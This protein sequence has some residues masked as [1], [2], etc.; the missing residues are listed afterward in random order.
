MGQLGNASVAL[1]RIPVA[2][3]GV[4]AFVSVS[5]GE[6]HT[7]GIDVAHTLYCWGDN[8][9]GQLGDGTTTAASVP[10]A[11]VGGLS[12]YSV[13]A[14]A[15]HTCAIATNN[16]AYC[17]G[18]NG[19]G[20]LGSGTANAQGGPAAVIGGHDFTSI[21]S[22]AIHSCAVDVA[23]RAWCWGA[24]YWGQ[25]GTGSWYPRS[26]E[27]VAVV[28]GFHF[29]S[30]T[31]GLYAYSDE[32]HNWITSAHTCGMTNDAIALCW[33]DNLAG[34]LGGGIM[35]SSSFRPVRVGPWP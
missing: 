8:S 17:W 26:S 25:L 23:A 6:H 31:A 16:T 24:N 34:Q 28:G 29:A 33:G 9:A 5:A 30:I 20:Q 1:S 15:E 19:S 11:V 21:A 2:V 32:S 13:S 14:G 27:P 35:E 18:S 10:T 22:G 7:C 3:S 4:T 12:W